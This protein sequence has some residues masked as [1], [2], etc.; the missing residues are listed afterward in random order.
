MRPLTKRLLVSSSVALAI[1][2]PGIW[3]WRQGVV[4]KRTAIS[5]KSIQRSLAEE[6]FTA[7][8]SALQG[9]ADSSLRESK[10]KEIR[11]A[12][13][14]KALAVRDT[15]LIRVAIGE[16]GEDWLDPKILE[17]ADLELAREAVHARDFV[18][19]VAHASKW[20][21]KS[22]IPGQWQLLE[23]DQLLA[24]KLPEDALTLL[25]GIKLAGAEDAQRL[26]RVALLESKEPWKA[27]TTIDEG[28][29]VDP[30]NA[31]LLSF[32]A[33]I[34]E[35]AGRLADARLDYVAAVLS[36]R[37]NPVFRE[38]L[39]NFYLRTGDISAAAETWRD[40][41]A[42]TGLG[43]YAF[44]SWFWSR[45]SG[46]RLT[47]PLPQVRERAWRGFVAQLTAAEDNMFWNDSLD[48]A[49]AGIRGGGNRP[50]VA[51]L[52]LLE[53]IRKSDITDARGKLE[54]GFPRDADQLCP[55]LTMRL[56][57]NLVAADGGDPR[58]S[59]AGRSI[60]KPADGSHPFVN[61]FAAWSSNPGKTPE[62]ARF[63]SWLAQP[64]ALAGTLLASGWPGASV[65]V[66]NGEHLKPSGDWPEWF[67]YGYAKSILV[68][69]GKE[70]A[71]G[72][73][74]KLPARTS[75]ADLL[76][77]EIRLTS[78]STEQGLDL[79]RKVAATGSAHASRASWTLALAELDRGN[80]RG[81]REITLA[82]PSL[83]GS[84]QGKE[85]L[86]RAALAEGSK[87]ETLRIYQELGGKS[88]DAM[89]YLSKEAFA[90]GDF[91]AARQWTG[92]LARRF[93]EQPA[94]RR[95]LLKID[96]VDTS[97]KR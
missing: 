58:I 51:W 80:P 73:L 45:M 70:A 30:R 63:L 78:G 32:R 17:A 2:I 67:D 40:A 59:L 14:E 20:K 26:V 61:D 10:E 3:L 87:D 69:D 95:N 84:V 52:K 28:L 9:L 92:E 48:V 8:R 71:R 72:W 93:P 44:K 53:S 85:I 41:A 12:E 15:G 39:A 60:P 1:L 29:M 68:R 5:T 74:E 49:I 43:I 37:G 54:A 66:G 47:P 82:D 46:V 11:S 27:M 18:S 88:A 57:A 77:G 7:A 86:A 90:A 33:Q 6:D 19:Y 36:E 31:D 55:G 38:I 24:R 75:A 97:R 94:F 50:E 83:T 56:L 79:L 76:L 81:A 89:I 25:K 13:L 35:A 65:I 62:S 64:Q 91:D 16:R 96:E 4:A 34:E 42:D 22:A 21:G 23:A